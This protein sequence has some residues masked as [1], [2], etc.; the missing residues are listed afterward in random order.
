[1]KKLI[2][3]DIH[4]RIEFDQ[5]KYEYLFNLFS[6]DFDEIILNGD[7]WEA[8]YV[9]H[10]MIMNSNWRPLFDLLKS[11]NVTYI[12]GNHDQEQYSKELAI[13]I[14][15][16]QKH[17]IE[18]SNDTNCFFVEHG[19]LHHDLVLDRISKPDYL[20]LK[21]IND[22]ISRFIEG[23]L[24]KITPSHGFTKI[25][26][27]NVLSNTEEIRKEKKLVFGHTHFAEDNKIDNY[28]NSGY[29]YNGKRQYLVVYDDG[30]RLVKN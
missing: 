11:K 21:N 5:K 25:F 6:Q 22:R 2:I 26:T 16:R 1:M 9:D 10:D 23:I 15:K 18:F 19:H 24:V 14:S 20:L 29:N 12:Y 30:Y 3:S 27:M 4:L 13:Y 17:S 8:L 28:I 7:F